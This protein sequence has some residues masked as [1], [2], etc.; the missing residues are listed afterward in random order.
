MKAYL[1]DPENRT[2]TEVDHDDTIEDIYAKI[3]A[4]CFDV[5]RLEDGDG[6]YVDDEGLMKS[7]DVDMDPWR[8]FAVTD[9]EGITLRHPVLSGLGLVLGCDSEGGS[10]EPRITIE[11]LRARVI[12]LPNA[13]GARLAERAL[14]MSGQVRMF[15]TIQQMQDFLDCANGRR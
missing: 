5:A 11:E 8:F 2:I 12:W 3:G 9:P 14:S 6:I 1:I 4:D 15:D 13:T 7:S 10:C